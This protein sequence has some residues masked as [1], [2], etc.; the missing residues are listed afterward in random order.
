MNAAILPQKHRKN[1]TTPAAAAKA[2]LRSKKGAVAT[3]GRR[4]ASDKQ[5]VKKSLSEIALDIARSLPDLK[6]DASI[7][8][9]KLKTILALAGYIYVLS[10]LADLLEAVPKTIKSL[11]GLLDHLAACEA[12][13]KRSGLPQGMS[14]SNYRKVIDTED[15][16]R[17]D[18]DMLN[19]GKYLPKKNILFLGR[20]DVGKTH[21][22]TSLGV[23]ALARG[24]SVLFIKFSDLAKM[25]IANGQDSSNQQALNEYR[26]VDL[27]IVDG[28]SACTHSAEGCR[29]VFELLA[30]RIGKSSTIFTSRIDIMKW[31]KLFKAAGENVEKVAGKLLD[32][33]HIFILSHVPQSR[34]KTSDQDDLLDGSDEW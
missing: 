2:A 11:P 6:A 13:L 33:D 25:L 5:S 23:W 4:V 29:L 14:M 27:L 22:A 19:N 7:N 32:Y 31:G 34:T 18:T 1:N 10:V 30:G 16:D 20:G 21:R 24:K 28:V 26:N 12:R 17:E 9:D 8:I 3:R 15:Y